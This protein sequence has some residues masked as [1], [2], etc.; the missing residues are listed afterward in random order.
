MPTYT[1]ACRACQQ[2]HDRF[3]SIHSSPHHLRACPRCGKRAAKRLIGAGAGFD[4]GTRVEY[5]RYDFQMP[6]A[7]N[8]PGKPNVLSR[9][10]EKELCERLGYRM[11][12]GMSKDY[13][14]G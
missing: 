2:E 11:N 9:Q 14:P 7:D 8:T 5:P 6:L 1:Y 12:Q 4:A 13:V 3:E 10:H